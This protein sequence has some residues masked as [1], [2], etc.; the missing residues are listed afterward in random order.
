MRRQRRR[1]ICRHRHGRR[2]VAARRQ[3]EKTARRV[4]HFLAMPASHEAA[5]RRELRGLDTEDGFTEGAA[6]YEEHGGR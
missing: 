3:F 5:T 4:E 1:H 2:E 6:R